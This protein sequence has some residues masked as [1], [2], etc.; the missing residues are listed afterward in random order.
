MYKIIYNTVTLL[1]LFQISTACST[2]M[3]IIH[4]YTTT[5]SEHYRNQALDM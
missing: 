2:I 3:Q 1:Y 4:N 5:I